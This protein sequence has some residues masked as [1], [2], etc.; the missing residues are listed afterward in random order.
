M[1]KYTQKTLELDENYWGGYHM[2]AAIKGAFEFKNDEAASAFKHSLELNPNEMTTLANYG[3]NNISLGKFDLARKLIDRALNIDPLSDFANL[4]GQYAE[5]CK[6]KFAKVELHLKKYLESDPPF[7]WG[8]WFLWRTYSFLDR[9]KEA[10]QVLKKIF[11]NVGSI[12]MVEAINKTN[13][14]NALK[15]IAFGMAQSYPTHYSSPYN[16]A[17]LFAHAGEKEQALKWLKESID[18]IDPKSHY[19]SVDPEFQILHNDERFKEYVK[20]VGMN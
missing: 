20:R 4:V 19:L 15:T 12:K 17:I 18:V 1:K 5:F 8:L 3:M 9:K 2:L 6:M 11:T 14:D 13:T 7:L 10:I 16:I